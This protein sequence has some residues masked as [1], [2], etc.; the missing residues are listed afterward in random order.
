[1]DYGPYIS[2]KNWRQWCRTRLPLAQMNL[3][4]GRVGVAMEV[5]GIWRRIG[6]RRVDRRGRHRA[7]KKSGG[8]GNLSGEIRSAFAITE[9]G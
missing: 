3:I 9:R 4:T 1:V 6:Q 7:A 2:L 8:C 5:F